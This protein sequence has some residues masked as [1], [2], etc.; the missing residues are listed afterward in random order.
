MRIRVICAALLMLPAIAMA[1]VNTKNGNFYISYTDINQRSDAK[2]GEHELGL[3]RTYN[4]KA[5]GI[6]WFGFGWGT[7]YEARLMVMPDGSV[8]AQENGGSGQESYYPPQNG[9]DLRAGVDRIVAAVI[10]REQL[11]P[12]AAETLRK[13]LLANEDLRRTHV[14]KYGIK[15][16]LPVGGEVQVSSCNTITRL[17]DE[18]RRTQCG[19]STDYFDLDGRL[20]R[21]E[22]DD[23]KVN[24]H[25]AGK[26]PN[27]IED[28]LGQKI[29]LTWTMAGHISVAQTDKAALVITYTYDERDNLLLSNE[30][31]GNFYKYAYD[32]NHNMTRIGYIDQTHMDMTYDDKSLVTSVTNTDGTKYSY[33]Y[34]TDPDNP[35][36]HYWTVTTRTAPGEEPSSQEEEYLLTTDA[37]G[38]ERLSGLT[39]TN[40]ERKQDII[41]DE[42]GRVKRIQKPSGGFTEYTYHPLLNK[43]SAVLTEDGKA[44]FKYN[45]AGDLIRAQ[46][47]Q[48]QLITLEYDNS[49]HIQR[50]IEITKL[51]SKKSRR[52]LLFTYNTQG[53]PTRIK[54]VGK[55]Q[56]DVEYDEQGEISNVESK[57][58]AKMAIEVTMAFQTLL[59]VVKVAGVDFSM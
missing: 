39:R 1:G 41:W 42:K 49:K 11:N 57:Q 33:A 32:I 50:M 26:Y 15:S 45:K 7:P 13:K 17:N 47:S 34:R 8:V 40:G 35:S 55:G 28:S 25:Y 5:S 46:N 4:S 16:Q 54:L 43:I 24:I 2:S 18:Y 20:I 36:S 22:L 27:K 51:K 58:G 44:E 23:Y 37:A 3:T 12:E 6:G 38:V 48:G 53:K 59:K 10:E 52:E 56:L 30:I 14:T 31:G 9:G 29:L 21:K 19:D